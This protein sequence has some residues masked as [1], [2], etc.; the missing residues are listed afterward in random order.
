MKTGAGTLR[1]RRTIEPNKNDATVVAV[2]AA[3]YGTPCQMCQAAKVAAM[4]PTS[5]SGF[6]FQ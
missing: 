2:M 3:I 6:G 1:Q 4:A 5:N